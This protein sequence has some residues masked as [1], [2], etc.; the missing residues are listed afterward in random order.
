[1]RKKNGWVDEFNRTFQPDLRDKRYILPVFSRSVKSKK[2]LSIE[3]GW[4]SR[5]VSDED[6]G[7]GWSWSRIRLSFLR[8]KPIQI[9]I[10]QQMIKQP[11]IKDHGTRFLGLYSSCHS[12]GP[13]INKPKDELFFFPSGRTKRLPRWSTLKSREKETYLW[14]FQYSNL[15]IY[16]RSGFFCFERC[17]QLSC[18]L[19][20]LW[21]A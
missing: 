21:V 17:C 8:W 11:S 6:G 5:L 9:T 3:W 20:R 19:V 7:D 15:D 4:L 16:H 10:P 2:A 13:N 18:V 1:M 12:W 14:C